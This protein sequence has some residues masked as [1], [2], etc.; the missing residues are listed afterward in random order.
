[1]N[2]IP[3]QYSMPIPGDEVGFPLTRAALGP[4][5]AMSVYLAHQAALVATE[6]ITAT[7]KSA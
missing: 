1:M 7:L 3:W 4:V 2:N 6:H 5:R